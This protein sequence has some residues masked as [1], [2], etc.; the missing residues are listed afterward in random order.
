LNRR[1]A[2]DMIAG[3]RDRSGVLGDDAIEP[4][5]R[6]LLQVSALVCALPW[7]RELTLDPVA[8][9]GDRVEIAAARLVVDPQRSGTGNYDHMAIHP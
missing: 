2:E 9:L 6:L 3:A 4:P 7:V 5:V 1:L 8:V